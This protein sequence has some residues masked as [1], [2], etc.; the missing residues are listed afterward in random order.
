MCHLILGRQKYVYKNVMLLS[1]DYVL[2]VGTTHNSNLD[3]VPF[4]FGSTKYVYK[5]VMLLSI[6]YVLLVGTT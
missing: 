2:L 5:N 1:I 3:D 4:N 6:N